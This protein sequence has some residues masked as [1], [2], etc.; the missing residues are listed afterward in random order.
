MPL[1]KW[2]PS[3]FDQFNQFDDM[4]SELSPVSGLT[5]SGAYPAL[6]IYQ[7]EKNVMVEAQLTGINPADVKLSIDNDVLTLEGKVEKKTEVDEKNYYRKEIKCGS[8]HRSVALPAAV[9][10]NQA[11][12]VYEDGVLK[13][14]IPKESRNK[15]K[16]I[17]IKMANEKK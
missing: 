1:I 8:F 16:S 11:E 5:A 17:Q 3:L 10:G 9:D 13:I 6:D 2:T 4:F 14:S 7:N 12:A 15:A